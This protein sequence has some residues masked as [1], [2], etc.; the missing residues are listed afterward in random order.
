[1]LRG[2]ASCQWS[3]SDRKF[4]GVK[5]LRIKL[6]LVEGFPPQNVRGI[7]LRPGIAAVAPAMRSLCRRPSRRRTPRSGPDDTRPAS[8]RTIWECRIVSPISLVFSEAVPWY[9][10]PKPVVVGL[11]AV[12][13][14]G[15]GEAWTP[16]CLS[17]P[18]KNS[19]RPAA[20]FLS[21]CQ[22]L[23]TAGPPTAGCPR[24][25]GNGPT[26][27]NLS[28]AAPRSLLSPTDGVRLTLPDTRTNHMPPC[29]MPVPCHIPHASR[30][31]FFTKFW[32]HMRTYKIQ[33]TPKE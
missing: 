7:V 25:S 12:G 30:H 22:P 18:S 16:A 1:M 2:L 19:S 24:A 6:P 31:Y 11:W 10:H 21:K 27:P 5:S 4:S 28:L 8:S 29:H 13:P 26:A 3:V 15:V 9:P 32:M 14:G 23:V 33:Q 17:V 20:P